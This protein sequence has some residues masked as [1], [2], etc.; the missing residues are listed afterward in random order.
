MNEKILK[1]FVNIKH[2]PMIKK[3]NHNYLE[4]TQ[5]EIQLKERKNNLIKKVR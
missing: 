3:I 1:L 5:E 4:N 2:N